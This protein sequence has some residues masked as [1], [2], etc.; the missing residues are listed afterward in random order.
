MPLE[1]GAAP[2]TTGFSRNVAEMVKSGHKQDQ[3]VAAAYSA[4]KETKDGDDPDIAPAVA[5]TE[6][7]SLAFQPE[8]PN[9]SEPVPVSTYRDP[10]RSSSA[11]LDAKP[12][13]A[14]PSNAQRNAAARDYWAGR[15]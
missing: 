5:E 15:R 1:K 4:A 6:E 13:Q 11:S 12:I 8:R 2:G 10:F 14:G 3:A 9:P 7:H